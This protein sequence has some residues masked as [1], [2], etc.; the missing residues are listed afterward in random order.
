MPQSQQQQPHQR[1]HQAKLRKRSSSSWPQFDFNRIIEGLDTLAV[2]TIDAAV[3]KLHEQTTKL[4]TDPWIK[5]HMDSNLTKQYYK[6]L[7]KYNIETGS[8]IEAKNSFVIT[9]KHRQEQLAGMLRFEPGDRFLALEVKAE[10]KDSYPDIWLTILHNEEL[11][12]VD[13]FAMTRLFKDD[14]VKVLF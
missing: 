1:S 9:Y 5:K 3:N 4:L 2:L 11:V 8:F 14:S 12:E 10:F 6:N 7:K 13:A